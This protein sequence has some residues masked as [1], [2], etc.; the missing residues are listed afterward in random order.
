MGDFIKERL[1]SL[2]SKKIG[3][4]VIGEG[5]ASV[6]APE[7]QGIPTIVYIIAQALVDAVKYYAE[8]K[9]P[10]ATKNV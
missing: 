2:V 3:A 5:V 9:H 7:I 8:A 1:K 4:A 6:S 10:T